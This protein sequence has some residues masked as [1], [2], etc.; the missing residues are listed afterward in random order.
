VV[1]DRLPADACLFDLR[2]NSGMAT[3]QVRWFSDE[4]GF[5]FITPDDGGAD[6]FAHHTALGRGT[7]PS[8]RQ[9]QR[10][11]FELRAGTKGPMA[12]NIRAL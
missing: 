2:G 10:V 6:L 1:D 5:G 8:L 7:W 4:K 11:E 12:G 3:G 9:D